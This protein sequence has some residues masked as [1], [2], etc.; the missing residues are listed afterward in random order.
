M[1]KT[2][3]DCCGDVI[4]LGCVQVK[5]TGEPHVLDGKEIPEKADLCRSCLPLVPD[6]RTELSLDGIKR[7]R[8]ESRKGR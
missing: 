2:F 5:V 7:L 6:L 3:C 4:P 8:I 1:T